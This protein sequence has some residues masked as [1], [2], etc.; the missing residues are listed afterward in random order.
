MNSGLYCREASQA[1]LSDVLRLYAQPDLDDG[2]V[3]SLSEAARIFE[4]MARHPSYKIYVA[5]S[6][7]QIVGT[8]ALLIMHNLAHMGAPSAVIEDV[9]VD[10]QW[11]GRGV[12][13]MMM[14]YALEV[15]SEKGCYKVV[16]SSN[17]KRE[18]AHA[19]Y[20]SLGF[21]RHGYSFRVNAQPARADGAENETAKR[22]R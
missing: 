5:V 17:L 1:D 7:E 15:A 3:L 6:G 16:L 14:H 18:R 19:F 22:W 2:K 8:F 20:E 10:P 9:A 21:E 11:Q 13:K 12:G 4:R